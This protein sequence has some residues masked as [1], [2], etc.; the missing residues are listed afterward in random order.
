MFD[1]EDSKIETENSNNDN[2]GNEEIIFQEIYPKEKNIKKGKRGHLET[3]GPDNEL[4][5]YLNSLK[6]SE[7]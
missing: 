6:A 5:I 2:I 4:K 3:F 7:N 1:I